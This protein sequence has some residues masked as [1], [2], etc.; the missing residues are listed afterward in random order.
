[1]PPRAKSPPPI[2]PAI[3][4]F[5]AARGWEPFPFQ[6]EVW[7]AQRDGK[8]GLIHAPT[9]FGKTYAAFCGLVAADYLPFKGRAGVGMGFVPHSEEP[10]P[11]PTSPLK[12]EEKRAPPLTILWIT[13]LKALAGDSYLSIKEA[14]AAMR[15][16]WTV[17]IRTGDTS[18]AERA[19][20]DKRLPTVLLT[21]PESLALLL[22]KADWRDRVSALRAV[23]VDE[24][25][26][27]LG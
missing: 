10:H 17:G 25:H 20:Q 2:A 26:E 5:F 18:S 4:A 15:P 9:G 6:R 24:W 21:T 27:L 14:A 22:N 16:D 7:A 3:S 23:V 19:R 12:G 13:P 1:M 11:P 8:S